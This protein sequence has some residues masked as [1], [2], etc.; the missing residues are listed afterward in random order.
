M[1]EHRSNHVSRL[2]A[3]K[4]ITVVT[5]YVYVIYIKGL[6]LIW[7]QVE[8][9][10]KGNVMGRSK[11]LIRKW[12]DFSN[13]SLVG[14]NKCG[15][16]LYSVSYIHQTY[17]WRVQ[18]IVDRNFCVAIILWGNPLKRFL[19]QARI[20]PHHDSLG[21]LWIKIVQNAVIKI[22]LVRFFPGK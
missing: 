1:G 11:L 14:M 21:D 15:A 2:F 18:N 7:T 13:F 17:F 10:R 3:D 8:L 20:Q 22:R 16:N 12:V 9:S 19:I 6:E 4:I 5:I